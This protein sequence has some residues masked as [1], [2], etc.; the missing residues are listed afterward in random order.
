M[1]IEPMRQSDKIINYWK[2]EK[3]IVILIIFFGITFNA[4]TI[5]GHIYQGKLIDS[6]LRGDSLKPIIILAL[7]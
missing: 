2:N 1:K 7:I 4:G 3:G 5:L 6:I